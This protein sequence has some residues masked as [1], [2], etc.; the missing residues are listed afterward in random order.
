ML[1]VTQGE[2]IRNIFLNSNIDYRHFCL[3]FTLNRGESSDRL[4]QRYPRGAMKTGCRAI[5]NRVNAAG[6]TV[7]AVDFLAV[8]THTGY[9]CPEV[10]SVAEH[11]Q[12]H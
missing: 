12:R 4:N 10:G 8:C 2:R 1:R 7:Q 5:L 11:G 3:E 9:V 6:N